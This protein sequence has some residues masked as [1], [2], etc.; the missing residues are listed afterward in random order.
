MRLYIRLCIMNT[1]SPAL[2][3][4][5]DGALRRPD[6]WHDPGPAVAPLQ[7]GWDDAL[8]LKL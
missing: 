4:E 6:H 1:F 8:A 5:T 7:V 2:S 3:L